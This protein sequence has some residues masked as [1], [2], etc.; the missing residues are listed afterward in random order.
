MMQL[1]SRLID[2]REDS[3]PQALGAQSV[4]YHYTMIEVLVGIVKYQVL[5]IPI[6]IS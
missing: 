2:L 6:D 1:D 3:G 4:P 5:G